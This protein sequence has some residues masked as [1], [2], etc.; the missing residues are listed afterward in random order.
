MSSQFCIL[1]QV[2]VPNEAGEVATAPRAAR[3][4]DVSRAASCG[5]RSTQAN[6]G[7]ELEHAAM[8]N[9]PLGPGGWVYQQGHRICVNGLG[10]KSTSKTM[11]QV[12]FGEYGHLLKIETPRSGSAVY[13][14]F[15]E[16]R[17]ADDAVKYMDGETIEG[18]CISVTRAGDR[19]PPNPARRGEE[20]DTVRKEATPFSGAGAREE[21]RDE[22]AKESGDGGRESRRGRERDSSRS[23]KRSR[24]SSR[25]RSR[26]RSRKKTGRGGRRRNSRSRSPS[27]KRKRKR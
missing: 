21:K 24:S 4:D 26:S 2:I 7:W 20:E 27:Q 10:S 18:Q 3:F 1:A 5:L 19:P 17:D 12:L 8:T 23:R 16:R 6:L 25:S 15:R 13:V 14:T 9:V 11:L 22:G